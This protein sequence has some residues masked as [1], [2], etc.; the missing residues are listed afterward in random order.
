MARQVTVFFRFDDP[1]ETS[2]TAVEAGLIEVL[3]NNGCCAT[4][5]V[6]PAVTEGSYHQAGHRGTQPLGQE[7]ARFLND[8]AAHGAIDIALHGF[9]HRTVAKTSPHSEFVGLELEEQ[10][11]KIRNGKAMLERLTGSN[12]GVFVP[13]WNAYDQGTL[14]ALEREGLTCL[15]AN[16]F[17]PAR[18]NALRYLP[19]TTDLA[20]MREAVVAAGNSGDP[21]PIVGVLM[22]AYDFKES[23]DSRAFTSYQAFDEEL[24]WLLAQPAAR[25]VPLSK[26]ASENGSLGYRRYR[27]NQPGWLENLLPPFVKSVSQTPFYK[28]EEKARRANLRR[29][30]ATG[31][32]YLAIAGLGWAVERTAEATLELSPAL[33]AAALTGTLVVRAVAQRRVYFR[34]MSAVAIVAGMF[35]ARFL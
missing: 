11:T 24:R 9:D 18:D 13:P 14:V 12:T 8:A 7:K 26:L 32:T 20:E 34:T 2:A 28:S 22:H 25:I 16:R 3:R 23:G 33:F 5:A 31:L 10:A 21:N 17:G 29:A 1:S 30:V 27:A 35:I 19:I 15:S 6:I 4:F